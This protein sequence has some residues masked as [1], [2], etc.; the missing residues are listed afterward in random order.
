MTVLFVHGAGSAG[1]AAWPH[2]AAVADPGWQFLTRVGVA[3]DA[4]RDCGRVLDL[5]RARG[6]GHV[7]ASSYG[8]NAALL[9]AQHE[10]GAVRSLVLLEPAC[11]D[12]ARG[13][14][15]VEEHVAA[16]TPVFAVAD[17]VSVPDTEFSRLFAAATGM[18]PPDLPEDE[19][20]EATRRL[21]AIR[22]PWGLGLRD[23]LR[24]P[25]RTLV[26]TGGE[27]PLYEET[28]EALVL[29]GARHVTL[30]GA[31]HR[32]QDDPRVLDVLRQHWAD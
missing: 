6:G 29:R 8:A 25:V 1:A 20:R 31:G 26:V 22:P 11:F 27:R 12:L 15:A 13:M 2:Q 5:L 32:V 10:P 14:P 18:P 21:R 24:L 9:A 19:L 16:M 3:D 30:Q 23:D 17:D 28:A 7:V 4:V